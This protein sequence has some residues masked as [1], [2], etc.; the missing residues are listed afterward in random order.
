MPWDIWLQGNICL[1]LPFVIFIYGLTTLSVAYTDFDTILY[2]SYEI[3]SCNFLITVMCF[4]NMADVW[5]YKVWVVLVKILFVVTILTHN[6]HG[7]Q[8]DILATLR[9]GITTKVV[10]IKVPTAVNVWALW[11]V[12]AHELKCQVTWSSHGNRVLCGNDCI[13]LISFCYVLYC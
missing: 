3:R 9:A 12:H 10:A 13:F 11:N 7:K 5:F 1:I 4:G 8:S 2:E 6:A